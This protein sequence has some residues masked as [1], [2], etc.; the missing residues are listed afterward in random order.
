MFMRIRFCK[1]MNQADPR[2]GR[3]NREGSA[4]LRIRA[5]VLFLVACVC[6]VASSAQTSGDLALGLSEFSKGNFT[7]AAELFARPEE[8][9]PGTTDALLYAS[10]AYIHLEQFTAAEG[11]LRRY[12][13]AH[14]AYCDALYLLGYMLNRE[15]HAAQSPLTVHN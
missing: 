4:V 6:A 11:A 9:A 15:G 14:T 13:L 2:A 7:S 8:A 5:L 12:L 1:S 10:K 3:R